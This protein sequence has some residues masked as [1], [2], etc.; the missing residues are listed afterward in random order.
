[1]TH[2]SPS[3]KFRDVSA[4]RE[5]DTISSIYA[6]VEDGQHQRTLVLREQVR[7]DSSRQRVAAGLP[8]RH[9]HTQQH[10]V[11]VL[12]HGAHQEDRHREYQRAYAEDTSSVVSKKK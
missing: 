5:S 2:Q 9:H 11:P 8:R 7:Q 4:N 12:C 6:P 10:Q 1:M 3:V